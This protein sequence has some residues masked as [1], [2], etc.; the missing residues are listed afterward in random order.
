MIEVTFFSLLCMQ[1]KHIYSSDTSHIVY[2]GLH[3]IYVIAG[4]YWSLNCHPGILR[5]TTDMDG[6]DLWATFL[7]LL[8]IWT[9]GHVAH[10]PPGIKKCTGGSQ[11]VDYGLLGIP[12]GEY[13]NKVVMVVNVATYW[14]KN[15]LRPL[16]ALHA[17][18]CGWTQFLYSC[19]TCI[20][21]SSTYSAFHSRSPTRAVYACS[22]W[23]DYCYSI[24][25]HG[26]PSIVSIAF[27]ALLRWNRKY[28]QGLGGK[29]LFEGNG[30]DTGRWIVSDSSGQ[31]VK[32]TW[33]S[34]WVITGLQWHAVS[35]WP[36]H[37]ELHCIPR[38]WRTMRA[39]ISTAEKI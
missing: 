30:R 28:A 35:R 36:M 37:G 29:R 10:L 39:P 32:L 22:T 7:V 16:P 15:D 12:P 2:I 24:Q 5:L 34:G 9:E 6:L 19:H 3:V 1:A 38:V 20:D 21:S 18:W 23:P 27:M 26:S 4:C 11:A 14:G 25:I 17:A 31:W 33:V 13:R 8:T